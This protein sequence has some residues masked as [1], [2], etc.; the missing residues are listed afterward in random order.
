MLGTAIASNVPVANKADVV[1]PM[2]STEPAALIHFELVFPPVMLFCIFTVP[3]FVTVMLFAIFM[4]GAIVKLVLAGI[5]LFAPSVITPEPVILPVPLTVVPA[6]FE[7][8]TLDAP[9][10]NVPST[11]MLPFTVNPTPPVIV[12]VVPEPT[13]KFPVNANAD[14]EVDAPVPNVITLFTAQAVVAENTPFPVVFK[15]PR[16]VRTRVAAFDKLP[17][18]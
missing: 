2:L 18:D 3:L 6:A 14:D 7:L 11:L 5:S 10:A 8:V 17:P 13:L 16:V 12:S 15:S 4:L 9:K 1:P